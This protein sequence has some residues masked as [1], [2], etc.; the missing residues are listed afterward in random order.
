ML[1]A[2][3]RIENA[4]FPFLHFVSR[5]RQGRAGGGMT[6]VSHAGSGRTSSI[7][8]FVMKHVH[9]LTNTS[10][11]TS[12]PTPTPFPF[13]FFSYDCEREQRCN[14]KS[15]VHD[16]SQSRVGRMECSRAF[17]SSFCGN[18]KNRRSRCSCAAAAYYLVDNRKR[19]LVKTPKW[20]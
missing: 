11:Q 3:T 1:G 14:N 17:S 4:L 19:F 10:Y 8:V 12:L 13:K 20:K 2:L 5:G 6:Q 9:F 16:S 7:S 15:T 18:K